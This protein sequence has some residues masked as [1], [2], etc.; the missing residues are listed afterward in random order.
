MRG[1][2]FTELIEL[3]EGKFGYDKLDD[4]IDD[5]NLENDGAYAATGNYP[6]EELVRLVVSLSKKTNIPV[7]TLL[8][9]YGEHL[10]SKLISIF[11]AFN[12]SDDVLEF[13]G[14]VESY[15]HVEVRKLYPDA[16]LPTFNVINSTPEMLEI[17]YISSKNIPHLAKGL[18][19]GASKHFKQAIDIQMNQEDSKTNFIITKI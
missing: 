9:V 2:V 3:I 18:M 16:D 19:I 17:D 13:I 5:A 4:V 6:F 10:F 1:I 12:K 15:I 7:E 14:S 11:M 8:E